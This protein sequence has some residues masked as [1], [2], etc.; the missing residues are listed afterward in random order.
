MK[1]H[2]VLF[3]CTGNYYRSRFSEILFNYHCKNQNLDFTSF[4]RGLKLWSG[5]EGPISRHT[6]AYME[7]KNIDITDY[8]NMPRS[9]SLQ[10]LRSATRIIAMDKTEHKVLMEEQY[11]DWA[12]KI[13]YWQFE[14]DYIKDPNLVLPGLDQKVTELV[15]ALKME[16]FHMNHD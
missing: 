16:Y 12:E 15:E 2:D 14:D 13:T 4:S 11:P 9:L 7:M 5:N 10:D 6:K 3:I 1:N 8:L